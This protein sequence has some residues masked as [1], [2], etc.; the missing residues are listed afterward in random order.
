MTLIARLK[1]TL[2]DVEPKV[3]RQI[4]V[5]LKILLDRLH[6]VMQAV[7]VWT[8]SHLCE[9]GAGDVGRGPPD[10]NGLHDGPLPANKSTR[11]DVLEDIGGQTIH[12]HYDFRVTGIISSASSAPRRCT[13][14][15]LSPPPQGHRQLPARRCRWPLGLRR[16][17]RGTSRSRP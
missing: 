1:V 4:E 6:E 8:D 9:F 11:Q 7:M 12:Y 10:L 16:V 14:L 3:T 5:P 17:H 13:R 2:K 15:G